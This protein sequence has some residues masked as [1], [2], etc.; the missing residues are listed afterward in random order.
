MNDLKPKSRIVVIDD[1]QI[2]TDTLVQILAMHG[3]EARAH[4]NGETAI[5]DAKHFR[6]EVIMSDVRMQP[7]DG[8]ETAMRIRAFLPRCRM[9][10][11]TASPVRTQIEKRIRELGF[12][13]LQRPLHPREVLALLQDDSRW[14]RATDMIP[15][16]GAHC[17]L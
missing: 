2:I 3:Y 14:R 17:G 9:I 5:A 16:P 1:E 6:P 15:C 7:I 11:F 8:I 12:E 4:Y 10:L 13:F